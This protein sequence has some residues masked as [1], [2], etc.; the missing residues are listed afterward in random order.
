MLKD[1]HTKIRMLLMEKM[2][3]A[4]I[5]LVFACPPRNRFT[6]ISILYS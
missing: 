6:R 1:T 5:V 3:V 4:G 2:L